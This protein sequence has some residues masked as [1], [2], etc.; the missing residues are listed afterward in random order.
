MNKMMTMALL[1]TSTS[2]MAFHYGHD[3]D[4]YVKV[5]SKTLKLDADSISSFNI[6]A[7]SGKLTVIGGNQDNIEVL[8]DVY[9]KEGIEEDYCLDLEEKGSTAELK[10]NSCHHNSQTRVDVT[11]WLPSSLKTKIEDGS[12]SI[13]VENATI[14]V[15]DDGSGSII[16]KDNQTALVINDASGSISIESNKGNVDIDDGSGSIRVT[17]V[18]GEVK[19]NDGSGSIYVANADKFTLLGDGS[20]SVNLENVTQ[21]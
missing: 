15:I 4:D 20:G 16:V 5:D 13:T 10:A 1:L 3:G 8:A 19:V 18:I 21:Q 14:A 6:D 17:D 9:Q 7:G 11:V 2:L 12:G